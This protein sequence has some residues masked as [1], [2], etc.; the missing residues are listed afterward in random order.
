MSIYVNGINNENMSHESP[1]MRNYELIYT[2]LVLVESLFGK[3]ELQKKDTTYALVQT[4]LHLNLEPVKLGTRGRQLY[5]YIV[6]KV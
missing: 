4:I 3:N 5:R 1:R 2:V 6:A